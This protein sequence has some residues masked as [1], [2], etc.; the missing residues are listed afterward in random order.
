MSI[1]SLATFVYNCLSLESVQSVIGG[2]SHRK[3]PVIVGDTS[4][5]KRPTTSTLDSCLKG[6]L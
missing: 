6:I 4:Q 1:S 3:R 2:A 5:Q